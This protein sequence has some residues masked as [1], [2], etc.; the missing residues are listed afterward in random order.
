LTETS[1]GIS[2][3]SIDV[4][5]IALLI[6]QHLKLYVHAEHALI[7]Y[8]L[9]FMHTEITGYRSMHVLSGTYYT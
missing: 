1:K 8:L 7:N 5:H 9:V 3:L 6:S 2:S 4:L